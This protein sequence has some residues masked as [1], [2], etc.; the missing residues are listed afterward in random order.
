MNYKMDQRFPRRER[1]RAEGNA[2]EKIFPALK[3]TIKFTF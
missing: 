2:K 1:E 3:S